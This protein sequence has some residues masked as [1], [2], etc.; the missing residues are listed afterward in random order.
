[1]CGGTR[2]G[3]DRT[4]GRSLQPASDC[5]TSGTARGRAWRVPRSAGRTDRP[6]VWGPVGPVG[7]RWAW[8]FA[9]RRTTR[10]RYYTN[11]HRRCRAGSS[12]RQRISRGRGVDARPFGR[13]VHGPS[14]VDSRSFPAIV[15]RP[16]VRVNYDPGFTAPSYVNTRSAEPSLGR[17][18][19]SIPEPRVTS[20][21]ERSCSD[22]DR[23]RVAWRRVN[24]VAAQIGHQNDGSPTVAGFCRRLGVN[25]VTFYAGERGFRE[26]PATREF[27]RGST[28]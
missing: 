19:L 22:L 26:A 17:L 24:G 25:T 13:A 6:A 10:P 11:V 28:L 5:R 12:P 3:C 1:V 15:R 21:G 23:R 18:I 8:R 20:P 27:L 9:T 4:R 7:P 16:P 2:T 14:L